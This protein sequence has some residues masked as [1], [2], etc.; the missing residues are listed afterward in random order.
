MNTQEALSIQIQEEAS[1]LSTREELVSQVKSC[2]HLKKGVKLSYIKNNARTLRDPSK[3]LCLLC[4]VNSGTNEDYEL[5]LCTNCG[6][7]FCAHNDNHSIT[8][9][10]KNNKHSVFVNIVTLKCFCFACNMEVLPFE[11]K[12]MVIRDVSQF[13]RANLVSPFSSEQQDSSFNYNSKSQEKLSTFSKHFSKSP[14]SPKLHIIHPGLKNMGATCYFNSVLQ[15]LSSS[16]HLHDCISRRP[17]RSDRNPKLHFENHLDSSLLSAF[18]RFMKSFYRADGSVTVFRPGILFSEFR[19]RH[20]QF[21][22]GIQQDAHELLRYLLN[23]LINEEKEV[24]R[25]GST[26]A[27]PSPQSHSNAASE[28][29]HQSNNN[30][31]PASPLTTPINNHSVSVGA[32]IVSSYIHSPNISPIPCASK[33]DHSIQNVDSSQLNIVNI[34]ETKANENFVITG[35]NNPFKKDNRRDIYSHLQKGLSQDGVD[36]ANNHFPNF[37]EFTASSTN[38]SDNSMNMDEEHAQ[39]VIDSLFTGRLVS[40]ILCKNCKEVSKSYEPTQDFSLSIHAHSKNLS[41]RHRFHRALRSR[42]GRSPKKPIDVPDVKIIIDDVNSVNEKNPDESNENKPETPTER[43]AAEDEKSAGNSYFQS[44]RRLSNRS[45]HSRRSQ[46]QSSNLSSLIFPE[47]LIADSAHINEPNT[48]VDCLR[49]FTRIEELS[50]DNMFACESCGRSCDCKSASNHGSVSQENTEDESTCDCSLNF[51]YREAYKRLLI[52]S[53][54]PPVFVIH[55][56]RF[57]HNFSA[58]G[59]CDPKKINGFVQFEQELDVNEFVMPTIRSSEGNKYR[60]FGVVAHS[61]TLNY[62][63]YVAYVLSH[64]HVPVDRSTS[65]TSETSESETEPGSKERQWL[66]ISDNM[67]L[68]TSWEEVSKVEAYMLFYEKIK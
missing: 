16:E 51:T 63:H 4:A 64:K 59:S 1:Q 45:I 15:V 49:N 21:S 58:D 31:K 25:V 24:A 29:G 68:K 23:D 19:Y 6:Y 35:S 11:K 37:D 28:N 54:L 32:D 42:F 57:H 34:S 5:N 53:P 12:N 67:V 66:Y 40:L 38:D 43:D 61:G 8:H 18:V 52:D 47:S 7:L 17:F 36:E 39:T 50:G 48:I 46:K 33:E 3:H 41:K 60:L 27:S 56:K 62:G 10:R 14:P 2:L 13:I 55:L 22:E 44:F 26:I 20:P 9:Y 65:P 30:H